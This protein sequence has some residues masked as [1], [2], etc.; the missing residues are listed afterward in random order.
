MAIS[1][2]GT[3]GK[4]CF[5]SMVATDLV[6]DVSGYFPAG[7]DLQADHNPVRIA[8]HPHAPVRTWP[9]TAHW[10]WPSVGTPVFPQNA[11]AAVAER[12]GDESGGGGVRDGVA[13]W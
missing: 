5:F 2:L 4:V 1:R 9:P 11:F 8:R 12:D 3:G 6:V 7:S 13:V 10:S